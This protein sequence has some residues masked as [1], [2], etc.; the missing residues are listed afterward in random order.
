MFLEEVVGA[1][2]DVKEPLRVLDLCAAP[3][4]K[5]TLLQSLLSPE[6]ILVSNEVIKT[7]V[8]ILAENIS[9]WGAANVIVTNNDPRDFQRLGAYFDLVVVD[10]PCSGSGLFRKDPEAITEW[11]EANVVLCSQRQ[12]RILADVMPTLKDGGVLIYSTCSYSPEEDEA[13]IEALTRT[14]QGDPTNDAVVDELVVRLTRLGRSM[15]LLALLSARI[16]DAPAERRAE[17]LPRHREVLENLEREARAAGRDGEAELF[18]MARE[19]A[20]L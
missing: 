16:E 5:S 20:D 7:R 12:Q 18:K 17:L 6:S 14:L 10:A 13:R 1:T 3:G 9:K 19:A 15:E 2:L 4:G 11:S 8:N